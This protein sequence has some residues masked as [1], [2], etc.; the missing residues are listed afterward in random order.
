[1]RAPRVGT[2]PVPCSGRD[3]VW[4]A[5][6][7]CVVL[8]VERASRSMSLSCEVPAAANIHVA[9]C[10][11]GPACR[12]AW[13][14]LLFCCSAWPTS[15]HVSAHSS[16]R[17][18]PCKSKLLSNRARSAKDKLGHTLGDEWMSCVVEDL[19]AVREAAEQEGTRKFFPVSADEMTRLRPGGNRYGRSDELG[20]ILRNYS[21]EIPDGGSSLSAPSIGPTRRPIRAQPAMAMAAAAARS[22]RSGL[23]TTMAFCRRATTFAAR[24]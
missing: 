12:S 13:R 24:P 16:A 5:P 3:E 17:P 14:Q 4:R 2:V 15:P 9:T 20:N 23:H 22:S 21:C 7:L 6:A 19:G 1:M 18:R 10:E 8:H 11:E